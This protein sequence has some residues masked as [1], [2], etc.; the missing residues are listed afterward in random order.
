MTKKT[1]AAKC[2]EG[3]KECQ[4]LE[5]TCGGLESGGID[6]VECQGSLWAVVP[7]GKEKKGNI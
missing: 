6:C 7:N 2:W 1:V 3:H 5:R 4:E